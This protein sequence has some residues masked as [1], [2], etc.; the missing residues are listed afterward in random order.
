[1]VA[2]ICKAMELMKAKNWS[3]A[4]ALLKSGLVKFTGCSQEI[5]TSTAIAGYLSFLEMLLTEII[6]TNV[7]E[8]GLHEK[9]EER[10]EWQREMEELCLPIASEALSV[11]WDRSPHMISALEGKSTS[12][13]IKSFYWIKLTLVRVRALFNRSHFPY[14]Y[15]DPLFNHS[16]FV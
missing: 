14:P 6:L 15:H 1:M 8:M 2:T 9:E 7:E 16:H 3:V 5:R 12:M 10:R 11:L 4:L 13:P